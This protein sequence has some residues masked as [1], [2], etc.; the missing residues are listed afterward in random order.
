MRHMQKHKL[1]LKIN[2][3]IISVMVNSKLLKTR[4]NEPFLALKH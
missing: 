2:L 3:F 1:R 4:Q